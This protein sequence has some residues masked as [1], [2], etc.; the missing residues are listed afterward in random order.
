MEENQTAPNIINTAPTTPE[1]TAPISVMPSTPTKKSYTSLLLGVLFILLVAGGAAYYILHAKKTTTTI[2]QSIAPDETYLQLKNNP[3]FISAR[4]TSIKGKYAEAINLYTKI[5]PKNNSEYSFLQ[6]EIAANLLSF[7]PAKG[8]EAFGNLI[9]SSSINVENKAYSLVFLTNHYTVT[10]STGTLALIRSSSNSWQDFV[11]EE[12]IKAIQTSNNLDD[13]RIALMETSVSFYSTSAAEAWLGYLYARKAQEVYENEPENKEKL[14]EY[15]D[16]SYSHLNAADTDP[17]RTKESENLRST[18]PTNLIRK[19][20]ALALLE[21]IGQ[22]KEDP[23]LVFENAIELAI[24]ERVIIPF[25][26]YN[27]AFYLIS[28]QD[29]DKAK[30]QDLLIKITEMKDSRAFPILR[31]YLRNLIVST[32]TKESNITRELFLV[33]PPFEKAIQ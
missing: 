31:D 33:Y 8:V 26:Y 22:K 29:Q 1:V 21:K 12:N 27:Y 7:D 25:F 2:E 10:Q 5:E 23:S 14:Q 18:V 15:I 16:K 11:K 4:D 28:K 30:I 3:D 32:T 9:A 13:T 24:Q 6:Y 17:D 19:A 20:M